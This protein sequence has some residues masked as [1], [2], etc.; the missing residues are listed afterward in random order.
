[1]TPVLYEGQGGCLNLRSLVIIHVYAQDRLISVKHLVQFIL[2][3]VTNVIKT[4]KRNA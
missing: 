1:M 2:R 4:S 3:N